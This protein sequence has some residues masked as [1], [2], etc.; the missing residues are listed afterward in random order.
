M[1]TPT[2]NAQTNGL[3]LDRRCDPDY[4]RV[5]YSVGD[6]EPM[7]LP[8]WLKQYFYLMIASPLH[9]RYDKRH[10]AI[11]ASNAALYYQEGD[12]LKVIAPNLLIAFDIDRE[13]LYLAESYHVWAAGKP[14][15]FVME[16]ASVRTVRLD[17]NRKRDI[18]AKVGIGEYWLFDPPDGERYGAILKGLR[19][20]DGEYVEIPMVQGFGSN[21]VGHSAA[22]GLDIGWIDRAIRF[23]DPVT[24]ER[25]LGQYET[26]TASQAAEYRSK[27][28]EAALI[29]SDLE[30]EVAKAALAE[31]EVRRL[32][33]QLADRSQA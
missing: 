30:L 28:T 31:A 21:I 20:V 10:D 32:R 14:P 19:L 29:D 22:L 12:P 9:R 16:L 8:M 6:D 26:T 33:A 3:A 4:L 7:V 11:V 18:Y 23:Y 27:E 1:L 24:G 2:N 25:L 15:D 5:A 13:R 17:L